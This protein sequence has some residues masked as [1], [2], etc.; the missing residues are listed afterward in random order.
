MKNSMTLLHRLLRKC[1]RKHKTKLA[2]KVKVRQYLKPHYNGLQKTHREIQHHLCTRPA[3]RYTSPCSRPSCQGYIDTSISI[4]W[5]SATWPAQPD[6]RTDADH[7]GSCKSLSH[8]DRKAQRMELSHINH[9]RVGEAP[10]P[11]T[12]RSTPIC[13]NS[14]FSC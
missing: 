3:P 5:D 11:P 10:H 8:G 6:P 7:A 2:V 1:F 12:V 9:T 13:L 4:A 14:F